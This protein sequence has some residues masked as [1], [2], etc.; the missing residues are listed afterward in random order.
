M[1]WISTEAL[2]REVSPSRKLLSGSGSR[3]LR[4]DEG[5]VY[6][7]CAPS[8][9]VTSKP[10][11]FKPESV[12]AA[13][14]L[15]RCI[16]RA[17]SNSRRSPPKASLECV[18]S[19]LPEIEETA[20]SKA[21]QEFVFSPTPIDSFVSCESASAVVAER[22]PKTNSLLPNFPHWVLDKEMVTDRKHQSE[23]SIISAPVGD[24]VTTKEIL[25]VK[26][27]ICFSLAEGPLP[28][29]GGS[30]S[31]ASSG[32]SES[33]GESSGSTNE[34]V[35]RETSARH[36]QAL[37][38]KFQR[39]LAHLCYDPTNSDD[40]YRAGLCLNFKAELI[41]DRLSPI[42]EPYESS[43]FFAAAVG[44]L[45]A[46]SV[47]NEK[48][49]LSKLL[50]QQFDH[51]KK[52]EESSLT[53][54]GKDLSAFVRYPW[55]KFSELR[56]CAKEIESLQTNLGGA[57]KESLFGT[58][59]NERSPAWLEIE[60][61]F[62]DEGY[63]AWETAWGG[64]FVAAL[65]TM[66]KKCLTTALYFAEKH[67]KEG[68]ACDDPAYD[69]SECLGTHYY[70]ELMG[71]GQYGY[72]MRKLNG[73][74]KRHLAEAAASHFLMAL[75]FVPPTDSDSLPEEPTYEQHFMIGKCNEKI[76]TTLAGEAFQG[77]DSILKDDQPRTDR[78]Y[79][80]WMNRAL[81]SYALALKLAQRVNK[82]RGIPSQGGGSSHGVAEIVYR[83]HATR[84]KV[85]LTAVRQ[86][87][88][89]RQAAELEAL[90]LT[91]QHWYDERDDRDTKIEEGK[92]R[93]LVWEVLSDVVAAMAQLRI[94]YPY[95]HRS[96]YRHTQAL[97]CAPILHDPDNALRGSL[98][99]VPATK[100]YHLRGLNMGVCANS[101]EVIIASLFE[102]K[103][104]QLCAVWVTTPA[105]PSPFEVLNDT[106][107]KYDA[108]RSKY[109]GAFID[110]MKLCKRRETLESFLGW[111]TLSQRDLPSFYEASASAKG[112]V[113]S[114]HQRENLST[115][116]GLLGRSKRHVNAAIAEILMYELEVE[117]K[118]TAQ[119]E[120]N[121]EQANKDALMGLLKAAFACFLRL[122]CPTTDPHW[123]TV[124]IENGTSW[125][126]ETICQAHQTIYGKANRYE[127]GGPD[128]PSENQSPWYVKM[129]SLQ[130]AVS[131][132]EDVFPSLA[133][134]RRRG[135][136]KTHAGGTETAAESTH[137]HDAATTDKLENEE[138]I[139]GGKSDDKI[140]KL[141]VA[142]KK[143]QKL[144]VKPKIKTKMVVVSVPKKLKV[145]DTFE[146]KV[147]IGTQTKKVKLT[148]PEGKPSKLKF[149]IKLPRRT[150][151]GKKKKGGPATKKLDAQGKKRKKA[152]KSK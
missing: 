85:L 30:D 148:V 42:T 41:C 78:A 110:C 115:A 79:E 109:I 143:K 4:I 64:I 2:F 19:S 16:R 114:F 10:T 33:K 111:T 52:N 11:K 133:Q 5:V 29:L 127:K 47:L 90:R 24:D 125:E 147:K 76:A 93:A 141:K 72:P 119:K 108:L 7:I 21:I 63:G 6:C 20:V 136:S 86:P 82:E 57:E 149:P 106:V 140:A 98:G 25:L 60:R 138:Q 69:I 81:E 96:I 130:A 12:K 92:V 35:E 71:G 14:Q 56:A 39:I 22:V 49:E 103:R 144:V 129:A 101:A 112:G 66:A 50:S 46:T 55:T 65:H 51:H 126:V 77:E 73:F 94:D 40:W 145:G 132:C 134:K 27:G 104:P 8:I 99:S 31:N 58:P 152:T 87:K 122:N 123:Q 88:H 54:L 91:T 62:T 75:N 32:P 121:V 84:L 68:K 74:M 118:K 142:P 26:K 48:R 100:S 67:E 28:K 113:P 18:E 151:I 36:E 128:H 80:C 83:I 53:F 120:G 34:S 23:P 9:A 105:A 15:Y 102:K 135:K 107:R 117:A 89:E 137:A 43:K 37:W 44:D 131:K 17:Y 45:K 124:Q 61:K 139:V 95:F 38:K 150:N 1:M 116:S 59:Q 3:K 97:L 13:A 70:S 146:V